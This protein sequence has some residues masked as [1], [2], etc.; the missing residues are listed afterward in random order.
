MGPGDA[1]SPIFFF[2][3]VFWQKYCQIN[4]LVFNSFG[5]G[6]LSWKSWIRHAM[7]LSEKCTSLKTGGK[8]SIEVLKIVPWHLRKQHLLRTWEVTG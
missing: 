6:T 4:R 5:A 8:C 1:S 2:H 7:E 3:A